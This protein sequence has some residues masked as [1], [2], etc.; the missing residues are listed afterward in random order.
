MLSK[1]KI[2]FTILNRN[3]LNFGSQTSKEK[4]FGERLGFRQPL[5]SPPAILKKV[6]LWVHEMILLFGSWFVWKAASFL[7]YTI[8]CEMVGHVMGNGMDVNAFVK[9]SI[10]SKFEYEVAMYF[11]F[12]E[13]G[14]YDDLRQVY[15][16]MKKHKVFSYEWT[17]VAGY[18][19]LFLFFQV[20]VFF[21]R[22]SLPDMKQNIRETD[23]TTLIRIIC[24]LRIRFH[25]TIG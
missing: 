1:H 9:R 11:S 10:R 24:R 4:R 16:L 15:G 25:H 7:E 14:L 23:R 6:I 17:E 21:C 22:K 12:K 8:L 18:V 5:Q 20:N 3:K 2:S 19:A 13:T